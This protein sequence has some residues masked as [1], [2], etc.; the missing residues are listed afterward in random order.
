M[1]ERIYST[2]SYARS[3]DAVVVGRDA[4]DGRILLDR[5]VFY[6]GGGGQPHDTGSLW[7]GDDRL[8]VA[9]VTQDGDGVWHWL[10][11]A[12]PTAGTAVRGEVD[13]DRR[14]TLMRTHTAMHALCGVVWNRFQS[15]VT[16]GN[17]EPGEGR[18]DFDLPDWDPEDR[19]PIEE[20]LNT[21]IARALPIEISFL[22]REEAERDPSLIRTKANLLPPSITTL[23]VVDIVGL[24]R[25]ADGG[26]H[27]ADTTEVGGVTITKVESKGRGFRRIRVALGRRGS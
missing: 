16:G 1:T 10:E 19:G 15:P 7:I 18:L 14:Y 24:D 17:M 8:V 22:P 12:L 2:D 11:G 27:V 23:R 3:M 4:D 6:P 13:W 21:Q 9:R 26:T 20:E 5:T 25:Q